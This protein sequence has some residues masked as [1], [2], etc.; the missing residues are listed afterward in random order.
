MASLKALPYKP[1]NPSKSIQTHIRKAVN[2]TLTTIQKD[3][4]RTTRT[5]KTSVIFVIHK[6]VVSGNTLSGSVGTDNKIYGYVNDG[7]RAHIIRPKRARALRFRTG[8]RAKTKYR[9]LSSS[10]GGAY[11]A[12]AYAQV[13]HHPGTKPREFDVTIADMR[14]RDFEKA[15]ITAIVRGTSDG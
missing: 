2:D 11:G 12:Y 7:T 10:S 4:Q 8:Y 14:Q 1:Y 9:V 3:F 6:S 13:V 15:V 5:W